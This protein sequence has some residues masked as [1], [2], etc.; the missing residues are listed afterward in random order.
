M[1]HLC[2]S[3]ESGRRRAS[4]SYGARVRHS[5]LSFGSLARFGLFGVNFGHF[6][7]ALGICV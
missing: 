3:A 5:L 1:S 7:L 6:G 4:V 2:L